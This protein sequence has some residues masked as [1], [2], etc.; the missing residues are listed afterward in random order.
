M[1]LNKISQ[2]A[3]SS[4]A[5]AK[6]PGGLILPVFVSTIFTSATILFLVQPMVGKILLPYLGGTPAVWNTCML[7]FQA[8]LLAGYA[9]SHL[10]TKF[11]APKT[12][13]KVHL[14]VLFFALVVLLVLRFDIEPLARGALPPPTETN[15]IPWLLT[16][17]LVAAGLPFF[18]VSTSAPLIQRWFSKTP[19]PQAND[20]YFLY[21][22][23]NLGS[24]LAL[25]GYP[26]VVEPS[27]TLDN[28]RWLWIAGF[29]LLCLLTAFCGNIMLGFV[30][31]S[32]VTSKTTNETTDEPLSWGRRLR[33]VM[34]A[35]VPSSLMLGATTY[36]TTDIAAIPL[37]WIP[38]LALYLLSF[39]L[40]FSRLPGLVISTFAML[41]PLTAMLLIFMLLT[42]MRPSNILWS[43]SI[44]LGVLFV[45]SM[46]CHGL[47]ARD[48]PVPSQLTEFYLWMSAGGVLGGIFNGLIA[49][50]AFYGLAEYP[51][52]LLAACALCNAGGIPIAETT[53][54]RR[55]EWG[56]AILSLVGSLI[57]FWLR[58][59]DAEV[60]AFAIWSEYYLFG[61]LIAG[62]LAWLVA[63]N[64]AMH[65]SFTTMMDLM[66][67]LCVGVL[68]LALLTGTFSDI[69][70]FSLKTKVAEKLGLSFTQVQAVLALGVPLIICYTF[71]DRPFRLALG[72]GAVI[73]ASSLNGM[74]DSGMVTQRRGFFG[75]LQVENRREDGMVVRRL[76]HGTTLHGMQFMD[77]AMMD[78]PLTY[79]HRSGPIG[80]IVEKCFG[81]TLPETDEQKKL[82]LQ[83]EGKP[84]ERLPRLAVIG[85]GTGSM[86]AYARSDQEMTFFDIDPLVKSFSYDGNG[87]YFGYVA[88][89]KNRGAKM[90]IRMGDARIRMDQEPDGKYDLIVVDAF[91]SDAIPVHL[92]TL[93]AL[94]IFVQKMTPNG[95]V[96]FHVSNRYLNLV[97]V[98][99]NLAEKEGLSI[100]YNSDNRESW[101]G[102]T[103][104]SWVALSRSDVPL[105]PL[106]STSLVPGM[107]SD[108]HLGLLI[109]P[110]F[111]S[112][113]PGTGRG[114]A[115]SQDA[116]RNRLREDPRIMGRMEE[117]STKGKS[118]EKSDRERAAE[119]AIL[120]EEIATLIASPTPEQEGLLELL[121]TKF[122]ENPDVLAQPGGG[123]SAA[124]MLVAGAMKKAKG[125]SPWILPPNTEMLKKDL[126]EAEDELKKAIA[127][128]VPELESRARK[129]LASVQAK[130]RTKE[131]IGLWTDDYSNILSTWNR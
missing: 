101:S 95:I 43:I 75:V 118:Q 93:E 20:P 9:Y 64:L 62:I 131:S 82:V 59:T 130:K 10:S 61:A 8:L 102:K 107:I 42:G 23:S 97:P 19:H 91:S 104:S 48:R 94:R 110:S 90:D 129:N 109:F 84:T 74:H 41:L 125:D 53:S 18:A 63:A 38:P 96:A 31:Q 49:P 86:A 69:L 88:S 108:L 78:T 76:E 128:N 14:V 70:Y 119:I 29:G 100:R 127:R 39:I 17:L 85:L 27:L 11:L 79:Y 115:Y 30:S 60:P 117:A 103:A 6:Y 44:H 80:Q 112:T 1:A 126:Q 45:A 65:L 106:V 26:F 92:I 58:S 54:T 16:V 123:F 83:K 52:A 121:Q 56:L 66:L 28:Q 4:A 25:V 111:A 35:A 15:P 55:A 99:G 120:D 50:L 7:F 89:A 37:L 12:Q 47:L 98:L 81:G 24:M 46:A 3:I 34:L 124:A 113:T 114:L 57:L 122:L 77:A 116:L 51:I 36:M 40:V 71:V 72:A 13:V 67:P 87:L 2:P 33:W 68:V 32:S 21:A 73:L 5:G 105:A 22:A